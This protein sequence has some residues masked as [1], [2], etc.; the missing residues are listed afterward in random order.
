M[1]NLCGSYLSGR[2]FVRSESGRRGDLKGN[3]AKIKNKNL[4]ANNR[5]NRVLNKLTYTHTDK[6]AVHFFHIRLTCV[7]III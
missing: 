1:E 7:Y 5:N 4:L 3:E 6:A 2:P